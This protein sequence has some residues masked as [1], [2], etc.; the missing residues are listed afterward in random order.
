MFLDVSRLG[1]LLCFQIEL[2]TVRHSLP[3][4][5]VMG[6][7]QLFGQCRGGAFGHLALGL[8]APEAAVR[9]GRNQRCRI[10][11]GGLRLLQHF[12]QHF[13]EVASQAGD[14]ILERLQ[15]AS[16]AFGEFGRELGYAVVVYEDG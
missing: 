13:L 1:R 6:F 5:A 11:V 14:L 2:F 7:A 3:H 9:A 16:K 10:D 15:R 12:L 4:K 8:A